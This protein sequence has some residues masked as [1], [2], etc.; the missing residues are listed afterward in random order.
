MALDAMKNF[1]KDRSEF[2]RYEHE[3]KRRR[4]N[5]WHEA[6]LLRQID[7]ERRAKEEERRAKE[8]ERRAKE[9]ALAL[10]A[11]AIEEKEAIMRLL[12]EERH[13]REEMAKMLERVLDR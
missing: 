3:F 6:D 9:E 1:A 7:A 12:V 5:D 11:K 10:S 4:V 8:E 13:A 2:L